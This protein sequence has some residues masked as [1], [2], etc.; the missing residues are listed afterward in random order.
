MT[1]RRLF[2]MMVPVSGAVL[3]AA[4]S[5]QEEP[6]A[7]APAPVAPNPAFTAVPAPVAPPPAAPAAPVR[8]MTAKAAGATFESFIASGWNEGQLIEHGYMLP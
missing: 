1:T 4:C 5:K 2:L 8:Q 6:T 3:A 7:A